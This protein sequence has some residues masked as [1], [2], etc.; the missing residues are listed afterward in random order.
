MY[1]RTRLALWLLLILV[2]FLVTFSAIVFGLTRV[3]LLANLQSDLRQR[4]DLIAVAISQ[5]ADT[6]QSKLQQLLDGFA[7]Q[8]LDYY[9]QVQ[10]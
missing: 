5:N 8:N 7:A 4:A 9:L 3:F 10:N 6:S 2:V 1:I